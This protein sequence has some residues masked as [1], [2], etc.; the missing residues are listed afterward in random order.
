MPLPKPNPGESQ[1]DFVARC[2]TDP[3]MEREFPRQDQRV[4]ICYVQ[5]R[6]KK[7]WES[8]WTTKGLEL[9]QYPF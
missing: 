8:Y 7:R 2:V 9:Q 6:G 4:V 5:Y 1:N 3:V